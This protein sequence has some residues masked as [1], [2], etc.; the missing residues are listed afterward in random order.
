MY[1]TR[2]E[3]QIEDVRALRREPQQGGHEVSRHVL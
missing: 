2:T 1:T 3:E